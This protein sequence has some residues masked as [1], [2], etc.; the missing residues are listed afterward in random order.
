MN[1]VTV[2]LL[3]IFSAIIFL[4]FPIYLEKS[5][6]LK[7]HP[8]IAKKY[9]QSLKEIQSIS[10]NFKKIDNDMKL[11][12]EV[13]NSTNQYYKLILNTPM[14]V[15]EGVKLN[16]LQFAET[17]AIFE[18]HAV[19]DYDLNIF[20]ENIRETIGKPDVTNLDIAVVNNDNSISDD[21]VVSEQGEELSQGIV[22]NG[23]VFRNF[24]IEVNL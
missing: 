17:K 5:K 24:I 19:T 8:L 22:L 20:V 4:N 13:Q 1:L 2:F 7:E 6:T 3:V 15:P 11:A 14:I 21:P 12:S 18:G 23:D 16:K 9:D 10:G